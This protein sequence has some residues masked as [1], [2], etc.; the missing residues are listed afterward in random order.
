M[1]LA[2]RDS[3]SLSIFLSLC[4][5]NMKTLKHYFWKPYKGKRKFR[6]NTP[7]EETVKAIE[8]AMQGINLE[9]IGDIDAFFNKLR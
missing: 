3:I 9:K 2:S 5:E 8:E 4:F 1:N 7:N 6:R